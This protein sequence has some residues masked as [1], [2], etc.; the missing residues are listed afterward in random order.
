MSAPEARGN[1]GGPEQ[2]VVSEPERDPHV[3]DVSPRWSEQTGRGK[4]SEAAGGT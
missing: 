1:H 2:G 4:E 3:P